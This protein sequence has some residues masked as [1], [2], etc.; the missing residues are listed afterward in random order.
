MAASFSDSSE[1]ARSGA[2]SDE[3]LKP[4]HTSLIIAEGCPAAAP[5]SEEDNRGWEEERNAI[6]G[7]E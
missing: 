6:K 5:I 2:T 1:A 3:A 7:L 4:K